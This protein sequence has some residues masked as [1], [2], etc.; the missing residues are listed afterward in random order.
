MGLC[1]IFLIVK[2]ITILALLHEIESISFEVLLEIIAIG[3][4][5]KFLRRALKC[6]STNI[7]ISTFISQLYIYDS[8]ENYERHLDFQFISCNQT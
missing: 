2:L 6:R 4:F 5:L 1:M 3:T 8:D 7:S